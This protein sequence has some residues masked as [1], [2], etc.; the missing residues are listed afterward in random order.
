ME[1]SGYLFAAYAIIWA[2]VFG[3][4]LF[5]QRKQKKLQQQINLLEQSADGQKTTG[6]E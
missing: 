6:A 1:N 5:M 4:I 2:V 3:Y